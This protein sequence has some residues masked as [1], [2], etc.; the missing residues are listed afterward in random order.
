[1]MMTVQAPSP[2]EEFY[3]NFIN[4]KMTLP[5]YSPFQNN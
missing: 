3:N 1:M 4:P 5:G 2:E